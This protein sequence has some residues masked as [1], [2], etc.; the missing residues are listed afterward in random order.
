MPAAAML[1]TD[2]AVN[3]FIIIEVLCTSFIYFNTLYA[4][5]CL[6][7]KNSNGSGDK[8]S[9]HCTGSHFILTI[10]KTIGFT[11][12]NNRFLN[13]YV[14]IAVCCNY[15]DEHKDVNS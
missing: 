13:G 4:Q 7:T 5:L 12:A 10:M 3:F 6:I 9:R 11:A 14:C 2:S 15:G 8:V 1:K